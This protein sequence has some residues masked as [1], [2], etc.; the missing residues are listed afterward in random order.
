VSNAVVNGPW[1][2]DPVPEDQDHHQARY[3]DVA[4]LLAG[5]LP[6]P[7]KPVFGR[8]TDGK[9]LF[10]RGQVNN[11]FGDPESG[12][13][14][15][16]NVCACEA[17]RDGGKVLIIDLDHNGPESTVSRLLALGADSAVLADMDRFRYVEPEERVHLY[18]VIEDMKQWRPAVVILD[19]V[20]ELLPL[21]G[22]K[23]ND[24]DEFTFANKDVLKPLAR[25]GA[26]VLIV[27]HLS[28]G[29]ESRR[30][31]PGGTV[32]KRRA[33]GGASIRV[34]VKEPFTPGKGGSAYLTI[35][36]DRHGG[37]REHS[38]TG[39]DEPLAAIFSLKA[40]SGDIL[41][42]EFGTPRDGQSG[43][44][45]FAIGPDPSRVEADVKALGEL[46][47][48]P[49]SKRDVATRMK[50]GN[51]RAN[52]ALAAWREANPELT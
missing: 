36:K 6:A 31:G 8:R 10:Y 33:T 11:V 42:P 1:S 39:G 28:K 45:S 18:D 12:K 43:P 24:A 13:T 35:N 38:P 21:L 16:C 30:S 14:W 44:G 7:P 20:G 23:S 51:D 47:P 32:A 40:F 9:A 26:C 5:N 49:A 25:S 50:W 2:S 34:T 22:R 27:D 3:Y 37:V 19:S 46:D 15:V 4:A 17:L 41:E 29:A 48:P 52:A